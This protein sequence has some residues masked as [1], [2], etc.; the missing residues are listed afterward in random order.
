MRRQDETS[1]GAAILWGSNLFIA[2]HMI[3]S[4][5]IVAVSSTASYQ[6]AA[7]NAV[8]ILQISDPAEDS[9]RC[10]GHAHSKHRRCRNRIRQSNISEAEKIMNVIPRIAN[11]AEALQ[12]QLADLAGLTLCWLHLKKPD[13]HTRVIAR[14]NETICQAQSVLQASLSPL[15]PLTHRES[16]QSTQSQQRRQTEQARQPSEPSHQIIASTLDPCTICLDD[17][18]ANGGLKTLSCRHTYCK[19]CIDR[20]WNE[21]HNCPLCR[22]TGADRAVDQIRPLPQTS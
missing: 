3:T 1:R 11:N 16:P 22:D 6:M 17:M 14:W 12:I 7:W 21:S 13:Q 18:D 5:S 2:F 9:W 4:Q 8:E 15:R 10:V 20:W 19:D